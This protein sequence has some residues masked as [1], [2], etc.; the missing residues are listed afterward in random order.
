MQPITSFYS[1]DLYNALNTLKTTSGMFSQIQ[2]S[3]GTLICYD[4]NNNVVLRFDVSNGTTWDVTPQLNDTT[5]VPDSSHKLSGV[6]FDEGYLCTQGL[7]LIQAGS[8]SFRSHLIITKGSNGKCC[9]IIVKEPT[10]NAIISQSV[11]FVAAKGDDTSL[12]IYTGGIKSPGYFASSATT[13]ADRTI[14]E[15]IPIVGVRGSND[16][17]SGCFT[18]FM[19]QFQDPGNVIIDGKNYYCAN[20]F[21]ILDE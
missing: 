10:N 16:Y 19:R 8:G 2:D 4:T 1:T 13:V 17:V 7:Y 21:A 3:F 12:P 11:M 20:R 6:T 14:L 15:K 18:I 5:D 9:T